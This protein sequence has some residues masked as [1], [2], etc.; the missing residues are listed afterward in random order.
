MLFL[1]LSKGSKQTLEG[2]C[3]HSLQ[4]DKFFFRQA[5][6]WVPKEVQFWNKCMVIVRTL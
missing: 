3:C 1:A 5:R 6:P 4:L 2:I